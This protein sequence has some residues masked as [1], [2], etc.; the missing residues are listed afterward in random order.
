MTASVS[1]E[2]PSDGA[3]EPP[4]MKVAAGT[5]S[6]ARSLMKVS[7]SGRLPLA[8]RENV[9]G[10]RL[11]CRPSCRQLR[12]SACLRR[13]SVSKNTVSSKA[14]LI[15]CMLATAFAGC[16]IMDLMLA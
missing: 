14:G 7:T 2:V 10:L 4:R 11:S 16:N 6:H 13:S 1:L 5:W 8:N 3:T 15:C 12:P 9:E